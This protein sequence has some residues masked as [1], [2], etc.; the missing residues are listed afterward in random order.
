MDPVRNPFAPGAGSQPP[1]LAGR[2]EIIASIDT[3]LQRIL[4]G[5]PAQSQLLLGLRGVGKT[6]LLNKAE[7]IAENYGYLTSFIE[8]PED[9]KLVDLLYPKI[10]QV[11]RKLSLS[12]AAKSATHSAL[13]ALRGFASAFKISMGDFEVSVDPEPGVADSGNL[14]YDIT[15]IFLK[16]GSAAQAA[17]RGWALLIDEVQYLSA[18]ELSSLIVAIHRVNQKGLPIILIGAG[19]PAIAAL[20]G[21]AKS[22]AERLFIFPKVD[23]LTKADAS[24]AIRQPIEGEGESIDDDLLANIVSLTRG[25]PYF[26]QE[27]G[28]QVWNASPHSPINISCIDTAEKE[29][30]RRLDEGF[31]KVRMDRLTP[32]ERD[33]VIA[34]AR[35]G[36]GPYRSADVADA[37]GEKLTTLGPRR[38]Q[39]ISKGMIYSPAHGDIAF[40]VPMF[41][42]YVKRHWLPD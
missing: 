36:P 17:G 20:S 9:R 30:L 16:V 8:A 31:F 35:L 22:Y 5:R 42:E 4:I 26:L 14:E 18:E 24:N 15:E 1:E 33:Y 11:L 29:A 2:A 38:A 23:A 3:S 12:E 34:M 37:L 19:L 32:K 7:Q 27:W 13:R 39:I 40:T 28:H 10:Y 6:V 21:D 25:Y 41:D